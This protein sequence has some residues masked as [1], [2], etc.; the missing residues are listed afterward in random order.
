[1]AAPSGE[2]DVA[3]GLRG[4]EVPGRSGVLGPPPHALGESATPTK[5]ALVR[6]ERGD[7]SVDRSADVEP[8]VRVSC[9]EE[10]HARPAV[11][12]QPTGQLLREEEVVAR[13][14]DPVEPAPAGHAVVGMNL[15]MA[16]RIVREDELRLVLADD[17]AYL[18]AKIH[19]DF[20]FAIL[21]TQEDEFLHAD[22]LAGRAL[23]ALSR[24]GHLLRR[25]LRIMRALLSARD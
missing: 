3:K 14:D 13:R 22:R 11:M 18:T 25:R 7:L 16:P 1:M 12:F 15:V 9:P 4:V 17:P 2:L 20:E 23:L 21:V 8:D 5:L 19:S 24:F 10:E 6:L